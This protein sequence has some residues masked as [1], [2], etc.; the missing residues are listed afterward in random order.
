[1]V[2]LFFFLSTFL[3][4]YTCPSIE[5]YI[6]LSIQFDKDTVCVGDILIL[7][8]KFQNKT[9]KNIEFYP[10]CYQ[11]LTQLF[12]AFGID[13]TLILN[14]ISDF[15]KL[16][17]LPP[18]GAYNKRIIIKSDNIFLHQGLNN[19]YMFYRCAELKDGLKK[20]N[21]LCVVLKSNVVSLYVY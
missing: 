2:V 18:D 3:P 21:K 10:E 19:I 1:M 9:T 8:V 4:V 16:E 13:E 15:T 14:E 7:T 6:D 17:R 12:V 20:Y 11:V 5:H